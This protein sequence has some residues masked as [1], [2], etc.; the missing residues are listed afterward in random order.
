MPLSWLTL[1]VILAS[2]YSLFVGCRL[3]RSTLVAGFACSSRANLQPPF[4][5]PVTPDLPS[6]NE[7]KMGFSASFSLGSVARYRS[8]P[9]P[10]FVFKNG[11]FEGKNG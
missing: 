6:Q 5:S 8:R 3:A 2:F 1:I 7:G 11:G 4:V 9:R 10:Y